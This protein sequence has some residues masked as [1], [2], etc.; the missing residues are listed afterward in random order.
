EDFFVQEIPLY[1]P[2]GTGEHTYC[3]VQKVGITTF[4]AIH[5]IGDA[6]HVS[7][8]DIGYAGLKDANAITRQ[9]LSILG[10]TPD[11]AM[12][13]KLPSNTIQWAARHGNKLRIGHL[14]GNRFAIRIRD[15]NPTDVVKLRPMLELI[16]KRGLPNFFGEQR[17]GNR[18]NNDKLG[19]TLIRGR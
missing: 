14:K 9:V 5:R 12:A 13:L 16:E 3:E 2:S 7:S 4:D 11:A 15:V 19:A 6:L 18:G 17:F 10:T 8:R 1:E